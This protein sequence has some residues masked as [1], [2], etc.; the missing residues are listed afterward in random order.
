MYFPAIAAIASRAFSA[1]GITTQGLDDGPKRYSIDIGK[2]DEKGPSFKDTLSRL[3][4]Q[5]SDAQDTASDYM[6][7]F[8][9][10]EPV[11]LGSR[12]RTCT[13]LDDQGLGMVFLPVGFRPG[14]THD[15]LF[16]HR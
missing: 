2:G 1:Q 13:L 14:F 7:K 16:Y 9:R 15:N 11:E 5:A 12:E 8:V 3:I 4:S 6:Q 10:G